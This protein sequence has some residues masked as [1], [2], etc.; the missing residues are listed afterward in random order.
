LSEAPLQGLRVLDLSRVLAG[1][2]CTML[3]ADL[4]ADVVKVE[5]P[6]TGDETPDLGPPFVGGESAYFLALNRTKRSVALD[7]SDDRAR[8]AFSR[9]AET[10]DVVV[11]NFRPGGANALG[12]GYEQVRALNPRVVYCS[13]TGFGAREPADR[14]AYDFVVQAE[15]G[16]M[17]VTGE[18]DGEP[19]KAGVAVADVLAGVNAAVAVLAALHRRDRT[20]QGSQVTVSLLDSTLSGLVNVAQNVLVTGEEAARYGNAHGSIAPYEP[21][22]AQNGWVAVAAAN[23][24][25]FEKLC[26]ALG[27]YDLLGDPRFATNTSRVEHRAELALQLHETFAGATAEE[28]IERL[29]DAGVPSGKIRGVKEALEAAAAAGEAATVTVE[30]P[31]IGPLDLVRSAPRFDGAEAAPTPP[32]LLGEHTREVLLEAGVDEAEIEALV[33]ANR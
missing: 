4:G 15:A 17:S 27:R 7:L 13:I 30:H 23:D 19:T 3:L 9:L 14:A 25:Q 16:L 26:N 28:W 31:A 22:R 32:P 8:A 24:A 18:P 33:A 5:R 6:G 1:P 21:L 12:V 20:G 11:E 10:A 29:N 2:Y